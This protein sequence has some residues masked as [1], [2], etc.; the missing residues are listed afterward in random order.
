MK[1][2]IKK[3]GDM[4]RKE[5]GMNIKEAS[6]T[7]EKTPVPAQVKRYMSKFID[8]VNDVPKLNKIKKISILLTKIKAL[9]VSPQEL[10]TYMSKIKKG[11]KKSNTDD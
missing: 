5:S 9:G 2:L 7:L 10:V 8:A 3:Q 1:D 6:N 4:I 11:L